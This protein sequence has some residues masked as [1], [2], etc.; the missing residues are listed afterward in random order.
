LFLGSIDIR[1]TWKRVLLAGV[2][3]TLVLTLMVLVIPQVGLL[4]RFSFPHF[5]VVFQRMIS[6]F[7]EA[8]LLDLL[9]PFL[10]PGKGVF[11]FSPVLLLSPFGL[12]QG[13]KRH[14]SLFLFAIITI[15]L[16][17]LAQILFY[18][19]EWAGIPTWGLRFMLLTL[20]LM[21]FMVA[22]ILERVLN[23][24]S[25]I[26]HWILTSLLVL[27][28]LVQL[29]GSVVVWTVPLIEWSRRGWDPYV[30]NSVWSFNSSP[31]PIHLQALFE[32]T[33]FDMA[34]FRT[35]P[36]T[37]GTLLIPLGV[38]LL[39]IIAVILLVWALKRS[40]TTVGL[41]LAVLVASGALAFPVVQL[42]VLPRDP[43]LGGDRPEFDSMLSWVDDRIAA[44]DLVVVNSYGTPLWGY[45]INRWNIPAPWYSL[46]YD[47]WAAAINSQGLEENPSPAFEELIAN[48]MDEHPRIL[49][50]VSSD[51]PNFSSNAELRYLM[52]RFSKEASVRLLGQGTIEAWVFELDG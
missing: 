52:E 46:P 9:G 7:G 12:V 16:L 47:Y 37:N 13:W 42:T 49:Y 11:L 1:K 27:S 2:G 17:V 22:P 36:Q 14:K 10:S 34:W 45:M 26:S 5:R 15:G 20:P 33:N 25:R 35:L 21:I 29:A 8:T 23:T 31:I 41:I 18:R 39:A 6:G 30:L 28:V 43:G 4:A 19:G 50:I 24:A 3:G 48:K 40:G 51:V 32:P 44:D 38:V